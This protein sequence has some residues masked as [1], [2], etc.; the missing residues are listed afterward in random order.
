VWSDYALSALKAANRSVSFPVC[1]ACLKTKL[2]VNVISGPITKVGE[3]ALSQAWI[4]ALHRQ[5]V[6]GGF[7]AEGFD[8]Q[9]VDAN[10]HE[11]AVDWP[12]G[13]AVVPFVVPPVGEP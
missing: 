2:Q 7:V 12:T 11:G 3:A 8:A 4:K 6:A 9:K 10:A 1:P 13:D 5:L